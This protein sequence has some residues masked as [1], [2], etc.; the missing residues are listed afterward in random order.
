MRYEIKYTPHFKKWLK[1]NR[2][3]TVLYRFHIRFE[4]IAR[5]NFG[6]IKQI[7]I[8]LFELRFFFGKGYRIYYTMRDGK[9]VLL[10]CGGDKSTQSK[11]ITRAKALLAQLE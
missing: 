5:G 8:N 4:R 11:D 6:D 9:I 10:L 2:D 3:K 1:K 7:S